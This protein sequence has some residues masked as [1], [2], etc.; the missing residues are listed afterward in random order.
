MSRIENYMGAIQVKFR[1]MLNTGFF[2]MKC[3]VRA[4]DTVEPIKKKII[5]EFRKNKKM[6]IQLCVLQI[7]PRG[8][9]L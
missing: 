9:S 5:Y 8:V 1:R 4:I 7:S 3:K 6:A 2:T